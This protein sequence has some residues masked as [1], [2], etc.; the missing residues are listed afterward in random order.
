MDA[1]DLIPLWTKPAKR[2]DSGRDPLGLERVH[3]RLTERLI[4]GITTT[5]NRARYYSF[6]LWAIKDTNEVDRP[7]SYRAF[8]E[9][10]RRREAAFLMACLAHHDGQASA[11]LV[12][13]I[14]GRKRWEQLQSK[15]EIAL[16]FRPLPSNPLGGYGQYY[17]GSLWKL[18]LTGG[19]EDTGGG[20]ELTEA[21]TVIAD[22]YARSIADSRYA[23]ERLQTARR[24][25][26]AVLSD[27]GER[28]CLCRLASKPSA[29]R[30][31]LRRLLFGLDNR[32][33]AARLRQQSLV[34]CL[35]VVHQAER[36]A[37]TIA[38]DAFAYTVVDEAA[39]FGQLRHGGAAYDHR[40]PDALARCAQRW[41]L[42]AM[43]RYLSFALEIIL[44]ELLQAAGASTP[45]VTSGQFAAGVDWAGVQRIVS[46]WTERK[47]RGDGVV[48]LV[49]HLLHDKSADDCSASERFDRRLGVDA[50]LNEPDLAQG[51]GST[52]TPTDR[53]GQAL[54][55]I[56][57][58]Y[59]RFHHYRGRDRAWREMTR[60]C[61]TDFWFETMAQMI[62]QH[63]RKGSTLVSFLEDLVD[64][65][66]VHQQITVSYERGR[67]GGAWLRQDGKSLVWQRDYRAAWRRSRHRNCLQVLLDLDLLQ[68]DEEEAIALTDDGRALHAKLLARIGRE[69]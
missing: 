19:V 11:A 33:T 62:D 1:S 30:E 60:W 3:D 21:G 2:D 46:E 50:T 51:M 61:G 54:L 5:T 35:D 15:G 14:V 45:G 53:I 58:L 38:A 6:Y 44:V 37:V 69:R 63:R 23:K 36:L 43:H 28:A 41:R 8:Q 40:C 52:G 67:P 47:L 64:K 55:L 27:Y 26:L 12:G 20:D 49:S 13:S 31:A 39:Y 59:C 18:L 34:F 9:G 7:H 66:I 65:H 25:D 56:F 16:D 10:M 42:F 24:L 48:K 22:A 17:G 32:D 4:P 68:A 57:T 29:E